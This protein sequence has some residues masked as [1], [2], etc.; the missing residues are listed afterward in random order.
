[1]G[2]ALLTKLYLNA[3]IYTGI[4]HWEEANSYCD[5]VL[6]GPYSLETNF[7]APFVTNN[8][9]SRE[10]I[11]SI[12]YDENN[13]Q[14]FR[15]HMRTLHYQHNLRFDMPVGPWN[16]FCIV[17]TFYDT[18]E[19]SDLRK[20]GYNIYGPQF[21]KN[22]NVIIDG[23]THQPLDIDP[24]VPALYM[25]PA[26]FTPTQIRTT[27]ARI[28]KYEIKM[29]A[30]ENLS[31]DLPLFR[32]TDFYLVKAE[33]LIRLGG[34]GD[35]WINPIRTRAGVAPW[36]GA[37]LE[38]LLAERGRE[39]YCEGL[40]RQDQIRF[41]TWENAWWEKLAHGLSLRTFPIPKWA[42]DA[43]PNLLIP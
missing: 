11:F 38:Q 1:M 17:P 22:G 37:T 4:P 23:E 32:L 26:D 18:Y 20:E 13:F 14:G 43:N 16:G 21:D 25:Q 8:E 3:E 33:L 34:N 42:T 41:G 15:I 31:N 19:T 28:G 10:I 5:S 35:D 6:S 7:L 12:P 30:K 29:G 2:F 9:N 40:R 27:G 24:H 36:S 39:L